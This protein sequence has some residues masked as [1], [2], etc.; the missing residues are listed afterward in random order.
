[1]A[2][3]GG[4]FRQQMTFGVIVI[5]G[6]AGW[7]GHLFAYPQ[8]LSIHLIVGNPLCR[9]DLGQTA[10]YI[11][12]ILS[13]G[14]AQGGSVGILGEALDGGSGLDATEAVAGGGISVVVHVCEF[15]TCAIL[16][17][18]YGLTGVTVSTRRY[19]VSAYA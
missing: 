11:I 2:G 7:I 12:A 8:A 15:T 14:I 17:A 1:M 10:P 13:C 6:V 18:S 3:A 19:I 9:G 5:Q 16:R 4:V